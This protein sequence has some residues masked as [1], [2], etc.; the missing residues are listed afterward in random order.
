MEADDLRALGESLIRAA[1]A[2]DHSQ[3]N[4]LEV[5]KRRRIEESV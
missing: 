2:L 5:L 3:E 1:D 4:V